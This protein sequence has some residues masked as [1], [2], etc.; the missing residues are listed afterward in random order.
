MWSSENGGLFHVHLMIMF[1]RNL[2]I[3]IIL[4]L[5]IVTAMILLLFKGFKA[6]FRTVLILIFQGTASSND[7]EYPTYQQFFKVFLVIATI[8]LLVIF[9]VTISH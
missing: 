8:G 7:D 4:D 9:E 6:F 5:V 1:H 2:S 3:Y